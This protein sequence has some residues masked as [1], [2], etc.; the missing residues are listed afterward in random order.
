[1]TWTGTFEELEAYLYDFTNMIDT[2]AYDT[3]GILILLRALVE[4]LRKNANPEEVKE[5]A[6]TLTVEQAEFLGNLAS[7]AKE[8]QRD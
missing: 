8:Y 2:P 7:W 3:N 5:L 4:N 6:E 1:M